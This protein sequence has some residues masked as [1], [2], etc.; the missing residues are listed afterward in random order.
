MLVPRH[1]CALFSDTWLQAD[2]SQ[3]SSEAGLA[4]VTT[5]LEDVW[6]TRVQSAFDYCYWEGYRCDLQM[7][8]CLTV[9]KNSRN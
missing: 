5:S 6:H 2:A 3:V 8:L 7:D 4:L 9:N 1:L